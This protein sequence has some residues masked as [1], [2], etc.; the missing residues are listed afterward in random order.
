MIDLTEVGAFTSDPT[1]V[2]VPVRFGVYLPGI[3]ADFQVAVLV[4]RTVDR[5]TPG[6]H[7]GHRPA[8]LRLC[9]HPCPVAP[10]AGV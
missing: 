8:Q 5:F 2:D 9:V 1:P 10:A 4:N 6:I 7:D 3:A